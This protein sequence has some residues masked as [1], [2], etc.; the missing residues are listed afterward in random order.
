M[1]SSERLCPVFLLETL[2]R[3]SKR[4]EGLIFEKTSPKVILTTLLLLAATASAQTCR[5][6]NFRC[7]DPYSY[8]L[9]RIVV[10]RNLVRFVDWGKCCQQHDWGDIGFPPTSTQSFLAVS[11]WKQIKYFNVFEFTVAYVCACVSRNVCRCVS[12]RLSEM[13]P[14]TW[15]T[16]TDCVYVSWMTLWE[17][18][19]EQ[20]CQI[21][22]VNHF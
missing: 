6:S 22:P 16:E 13:Q 3:H 21:R 10:I 8:K 11:L 1:Q 18:A 5:A 7:L 15:I 17:R 19:I 20:D 4:P 9:W 14:Y 12:V 2:I